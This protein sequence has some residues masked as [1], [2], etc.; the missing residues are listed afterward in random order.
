MLLDSPVDETFSTVTLESSSAL[1]QSYAGQQAVI[2]GWGRTKQI[3]YPGNKVYAGDPSNILKKTNTTVMDNTDCGIRH[4]EESV[5]Q[6]ILLYTKPKQFVCALSYA[7][8]ESCQV[9]LK[10]HFFPTIVEPMF[11]RSVYLFSFCFIQ[12]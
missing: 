9:K 8:E 1:S 12:G 4:H 10:C 7:D 5:L 3:L 6:S 2:A 11:S